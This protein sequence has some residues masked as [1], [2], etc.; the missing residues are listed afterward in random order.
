MVIEFRI[1]CQVRRLHRREKKVRVS[2]ES[3][4]LQKTRNSSPRVGWQQLL[5]TSPEPFEAAINILERGCF[6][7]LQRAFL[8]EGRIALGQRAGPG[9][10]SLANIS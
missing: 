6:G 10:H 5:R 3:K 8:E 4:R 1:A 2:S 9:G 7:R